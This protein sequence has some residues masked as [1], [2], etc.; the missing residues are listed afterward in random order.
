MNKSSILSIP[1]A[2]TLILI[3]CDKGNS[4]TPSPESEPTPSAVI[5]SVPSTLTSE[6]LSTCAILGEY[7]AISAGLN[8]LSFTDEEIATIVGG[9][10]RGLSGQVKAGSIESNFAV[11]R[12]YLQT[13]HTAKAAVDREK[14]QKLAATFVETLKQD[15]SVHFSETGLGYKIIKPGEEEKAGIS[16]A[17]SVN[18]K[19]TL[20]DGT[21]FD[22]A[23]DESQ[24][25]TFPLSGV[26]PGFSEGLQL[27]GKGGEIRLYIPSELGYG[28]NP[29]PGSPI[30]AGA[31]L[32]FDLTIREIKKSMPAIPAGITPPPPSPI[33]DEEE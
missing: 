19:G 11:I 13:K 8:E 23:M 32:V 24:P 21:E 15:P 9:F 22:S 33:P 26:I 17:V 28:D 27:I 1:L 20:I 18:Y 30:K 4:A 2:A 6:D 16:D 3:G 5:E 12:E 14:N 10:K 29:R 7:F 31:M 25:V